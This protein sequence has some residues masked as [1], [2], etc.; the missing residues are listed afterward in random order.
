M[1]LLMVHAF[2]QSKKKERLIRTIPLDIQV[3]ISTKIGDSG[4]LRLCLLERTTLLVDSKSNGREAMGVQ[5]SLPGTI[6][7]ISRHGC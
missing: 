5:V 4:L 6:L 1:I 2:P 7:N 3:F